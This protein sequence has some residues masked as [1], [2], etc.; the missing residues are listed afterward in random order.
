MPTPSPSPLKPTTLTV[1]PIPAS[2]SRTLRLTKLTAIWTVIISVAPDILQVVSYLA[3]N[4]PQFAEALGRWFPAHIRYPVMAVILG[5][6]GKHYQLRRET[7]API[8]GT[9]AAAPPVP[10]TGEEKVGE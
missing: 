4:D 9:P 3:L 7:N 8:I 5:L 1:T 2:E 10:P 6:A